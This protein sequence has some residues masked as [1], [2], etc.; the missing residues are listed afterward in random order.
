MGIECMTFPRLLLLFYNEPDAIVV[1]YTPPTTSMAPPYPI[2]GWFM[3]HVH[4]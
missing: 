4:G 2:A 3:G 1:G